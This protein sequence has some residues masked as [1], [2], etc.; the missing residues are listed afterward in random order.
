M[1]RAA[2][3]EEHD[4]RRDGFDSRRTLGLISLRHAMARVESGIYYKYRG[5]SAKVTV[6]WIMGMKA[7]VW[8][9]LAV[10]ALHPHAV[11]AEV[12]PQPFLRAD[13]Q[14]AAAGIVQK[15]LG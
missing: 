11:A 7:A 14:N 8:F 10:G 5:N 4:T 13:V 3:R 15:M 9:G 2:R 12:C 6:G 1:H